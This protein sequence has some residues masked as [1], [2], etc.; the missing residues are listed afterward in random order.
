[1]T[2][3]V[4]D[5]PLNA[6]ST[7]KRR[8][9][10]RSPIVRAATIW[11]G[12]SA[13]IVGLN[14]GLHAIAGEAV[15]GVGDRK[16]ANERES[17]HR[18]AA[19]RQPRSRMRTASRRP[20]RP[21][22]AVTRPFAVACDSRKHVRHPGR[23]RGP[24]RGFEAPCQLARRARIP[25]DEEL[26][27]RGLALETAPEISRWQRLRRQAV[28]SRL[29]ARAG[30]PVSEPPSRPGQPRRGRASR[31][32]CDLEPAG[33]QALREPPPPLVR[34]PQQ[35]L[36]DARLDVIANQRPGIPGRTEWTNPRRA[37]PPSPPALAGL[38]RRSPT[39]AHSG[40]SG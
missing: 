1:M 28:P 17:H 16:N 21:T 19:H 15:A 6:R 40:G 24:E 31:R 32:R 25:S 33:K 38:N 18:R 30:A 37:H 7:W 3:G 13:S 5:G 20:H 23:E 8:P 36:D 10:W 34:D 11:L 26:T 27:H 22:A 9:R 12:P 4:V 39:P 35:L 14:G 29:A 2:I